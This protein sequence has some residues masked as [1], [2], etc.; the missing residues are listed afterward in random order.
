MMQTEVSECGLACLGMIANY[1]GHDLSLP[2]MRQ[3]FA[4]SAR[5][6]SLGDLMR[7]A[8]ALQLEAS[9]FKIAIEHLDQLKTPCILHW[10][11]NHFV[12]CQKVSAHAIIIFDPARGIVKMNNREVSKHFTGVALEIYPKT[13]LIPLKINPQL[14]IFHLLKVV[15]GIEK[16]MFMTATLSLFVLVLSLLLPYFSMIIVDHIVVVHDVS[17][18]NTLAIGFGFVVLFDASGRFLRNFFVVHMGSQ[19][20]K[21]LTRKIA[22]HLLHLPLSFF[23]KRHV[24]DVMSRLDSLYFIK[25]LISEEFVAAALDGLVAIVTVTMMIILVPKLSAIILF[26]LILYSLVRIM[27]HRRFRQATEEQLIAKA[28]EETTILESLRAIQSI[29]LYN[30]EEERVALWMRFFNQS[31]NGQNRAQIIGITGHSISRLIFGIEEVVVLWLAAFLV[32][33]GQM[34]V[35][36]L[37]AFLT[38]KHQFVQIFNSLVDKIVEFKILDLHVDRL[39]DLLL[40]QPEIS[41]S[42]AP[43]SLKLDGSLR[44]ED[45]AF[46]YSP[47]EPSVFSRVNLQVAAGEAVALVGPSGSGKTTLLKVILGLLEPSEGA[48]LASGLRINLIRAHYRRHIATVMQEDQLMTGS[49]ADNIAFFDDKTDFEWMI[50]CAK[51]AHVHDDIMAMPMGYQSLVSD[52]ASVLSG[53]QKQRVLLARALYRRPLILFLDEATSAVDVEMERKINTSI[54]ALS[55]TRVIIAHRPDTIA[56]ADRVYELKD[57]TLVLREK[58]DRI[59]SAAGL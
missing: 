24:G 34:T 30:G 31:L 4:I 37:V 16:S 26:A 7:I 52:F 54:K 42:L 23:E 57:G 51:M 8:D 19:L 29:K 35:G 15:R 28:K 44:V 11:L 21:Q 1:H 12:V 55:I 56:T 33:S 45:L 47:L 39:S 32:I 27:M 18:V 5:G 2:G 14:K 36:L 22:H 3:R 9:P 25:N 46:R 59:N 6:L 20:I 43:L 48:V 53:G 13:H 58:D 17:L 10:D 49:I 50:A 41:S 38:Y 40:Q